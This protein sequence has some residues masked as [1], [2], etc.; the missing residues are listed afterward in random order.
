VHLCRLSSAQGVALL[1]AAKRDGLRVTA[2]VS[3][4]HVHLIDRS[5]GH[6]DTHCRL[7]PPLRAEADRAAI[8]AAL[9][10]GTIDAICSD[11]APVSIDDK[12]LP[13]G[14]A[15]PGASGLETLLP[16]TLQWA[17]AEHIDLKR[18]LALVTSAPARVLGEDTGTLQPGRKADVV[19]FDPERSWVAQAD[20]LVSSGKNTPFAGKALRGRARWTLVGGEV[21]YEDGA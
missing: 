5:I 17:R 3:I 9:A 19:V 13:F 8:R 7:D 21:R 12:L 18:A 15:K 6:Y 2:D 10:D 20:T 14:E 1:R 16:L 11:H 4:H